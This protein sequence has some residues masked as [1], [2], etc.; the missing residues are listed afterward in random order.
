MYDEI[1]TLTD[2][3]DHYITGTTIYKVGE[4]VKAFYDY[5]TDG[6]WNVGEY[7]NISLIGRHAIQVRQPLILP[8]MV[9]RVR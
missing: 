3:V 7:E 8:T 9:H 1:S 5:E 4:P 6:C 2:G